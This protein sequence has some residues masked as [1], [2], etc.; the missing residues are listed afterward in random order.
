[1]SGKERNALERELQK[2][3]FTAEAEEGFASA[4][5]DEILKDFN[6]LQHSLN[7]RTQRKSRYLIYRIAASVAVL[8]IISSVFIIVERNK[9][10]QQ[11]APSSTPA[12]IEIPQEK[13][14]KKEEVKDQLE[15]KPEPDF[16]KQDKPPEQDKKGSVS[17]V[18][19]EKTE[20]AGKNEYAARKS[21]AGKT[22]S[23]PVAVMSNSR[24]MKR[25]LPEVEGKVYS[26][27]DKMPIPGANISV[28]GSKERVTTD[29]SGRFRIN[30]PDSE[31]VTLIADFIGMRK[32]EFPA[33]NNNDITVMLE[34]DI[35]ALN[36]VAVVGYGSKKAEEDNVGA[37]SY[38]PPQ[39]V[40]GKAN[41]DKYVTENIRRPDSA[42]T[43]Q[44]V[45]VV[46]SFL[47]RTDGTIDNLK[48]IRSAGKQFSD[49]AIRLIESGPSWKPAQQDGVIIADSVR[50]RIV[51]K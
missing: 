5:T 26:S 14:L 22:V 2:D 10:V 7:K 44:R 29:D 18:S 33:K 13:A 45:V 4:S 49:E 39:P 46:V 30:L 19:D 37:V 31:N 21:A 34:P 41:F 40:N 51:F 1:M 43:G 12:I 25:S 36:E 24:S 48:I 42:T 8:M 27:E 38:S 28:K 20:D 3:P 15:E 50:I 23:A 11:I 16:K 47:V 9:P 35:S 6:Q 17:A 32:Q